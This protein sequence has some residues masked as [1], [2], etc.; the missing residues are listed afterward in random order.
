MR[1]EQSSNG[2]RS[3]QVTP[4]RAF[5]RLRFYRVSTGEKKSARSSCPE[6]FHKK[7]VLEI[8]QNSQ[9]NT[10]A[11][12][13]FL[14]KWQASACIF[15]K[16][17]TLAQVFSCKFC[18]IFKNIFFYRT[19]PVAASNQPKMIPSTNNLEKV[20]EILSLKKF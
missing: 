16:K 5:S 4:M 9:E 10:C 20:P 2:G 6:M 18:E 11:G 12:V 15:I 14:T 13:S 17:E 7:G 1:R 19:P 3:S 8:S